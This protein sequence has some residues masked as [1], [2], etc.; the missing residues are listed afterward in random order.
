MRGKK[1]I[2][3]FL[4]P[5]GH[6]NI[7]SVRNSAWSWPLTAQCKVIGVSS[8]VQCRLSV[9]MGSSV[10]C[11][12]PTLLMLNREIEES[13]G[14]ALF[15]LASFQE[16]GSSYQLFLSYIAFTSPEIT[17]PCILTAFFCGQPA[18]R[19]LKQS[20]EHVLFLMYNL[21]KDVKCRKMQKDYRKM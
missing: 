12:S 6:S 7:P 1:Q 4:N 18:S 17:S 3:E 11:S 16:C 8:S 20:N 13:I 9:F 19:T 5:A 10:Y 2:S 15:S 21:I 14:Q